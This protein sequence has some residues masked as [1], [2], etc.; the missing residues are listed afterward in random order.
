[1]KRLLLT[2]ASL[3]AL[4]AA[5]PAASATTF[6]FSGEIVDFTIPIESTYEIT[7]FGAQGG[8]SKDHAALVYGGGGARISG[9]FILFKGEVL[10]IPVGGMGAESTNA[11]GGGGGGSFVIGPFNKPLV[12]AGGGGGGGAGLNFNDG[13]QTGT[14]GGDG[15]GVLGKRGP[16]GSGGGG[17]KYGSDYGGG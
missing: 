16:G 17:G 6:L 10:E 11:G 12:I 2:S 13:G 7:A 3:L 4:L 8:N 15:H 5:A 1:M 14:D 9:D